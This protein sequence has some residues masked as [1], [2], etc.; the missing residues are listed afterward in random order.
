MKKW[1]QALLARIYPV[2][3]AAAARVGRVTRSAGRPGEFRA[4]KP[5]DPAGSGL[6]A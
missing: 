1:R 4:G 5:Y 3:G 6:E 2:C